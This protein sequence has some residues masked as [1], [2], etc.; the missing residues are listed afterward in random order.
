MRRAI[1]GIA[2]QTVIPLKDGPI[3]YAVFVEEP[4][5]NSRDYRNGYIYTP[6]SPVFEN[7][8]QGENSHDGHLRRH[9]GNFVLGEIHKL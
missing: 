4:I 6:V 3:G 7:R 9:E 5:F 1:R 2:D 8:V